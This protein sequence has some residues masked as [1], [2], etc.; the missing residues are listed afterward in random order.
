MRYRKILTG[1][2][3]AGSA[4]MLAGCG[5]RGKSDGTPYRLSLEVWGA[6]DDSEVYDTL[7]QQYRGLNPHVA[8][9]RYRKFAEE[10]YK[11]ELLNALAAGNG[12][13]VFMIRNS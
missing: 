2:L 10:T 7:F 13:D 5:L 11:K 8:E 6:F 4:L 12:P 1:F 3:I 9:I